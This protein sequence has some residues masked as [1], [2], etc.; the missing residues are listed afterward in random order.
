MA[1]RMSNRER[2]DR[3]AAENAAAEEEKKVKKKTTKKK[4]TSAGKKKTTSSGRQKI[5]WKVLDS[6]FK[7]VAEFPFPEKDAS[8]AEAA[9]LTT[10]KGK[11]HFVK[12][13][14]VPM[15]DD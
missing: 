11:E 13:V 8:E 3:M 7:E 10:D 14:G 4:T 15:E 2:I 12:R 6:S 5:V 9:R 1:K